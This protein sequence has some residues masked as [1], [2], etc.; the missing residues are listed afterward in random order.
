MA[1]GTS[2]SASVNVTG[3]RSTLNTTTTPLNSGQTY[4][5][6]FE[7]N[8]LM[9]VGVSCQTDQDGTLFFDF[10]PNGTDVNTFPPAGFSVSA[11]IHE[12]HTAVKL[13]RY[14][15]VR[16]QNTSGSNQTYLRLYTY[17]GPGRQGNS[18]IV[19][20]ISDD[21]D[22][23]VVRAVLTAKDS[24][25]TYRN[26]GS[27]VGGALL[28]GDFLTEV[29]LGH[30]SGYSVDVK[31]GRNSEV[32][33][34]S[35]PEDIWEG[36]GA[37]TGHP[38]GSPETV[39][40]FSNNANDTSAG[41]GARTIRISG[42]KST[43]STD[44]ESEDLTMNG[45]SAVTSVNTWYRINRMLVLTAGSGGANAGLITCRHTT[46][47]ANVFAAMVAGYNQTTILAYTVPSGKEVVMKRL[48]LAITRSNGSPGS[49]TVSMRVRPS[50]GVYNAKRVM[51][52]QTGAAV[53]FTQEGGDMW[54]AGTDVKFTVEDVSDNDTVIDGA[55]E[56]VLTTP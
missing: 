9:D 26:V 17:Y 39:E 28:T 14:F 19:Q 11:G 25:G 43:S 27:N 16:F 42:L 7:Q 34:G 5:G 24:D 40:V 33:T 3:I 18:P 6:T 1:T 37:Y 21:S 22:A 30:I 36:G 48:R 45:T 41:T 2:S 31:F 35:A 8:D 38:T 23:T 50:G 44:Y 46:T 51:E 15:R 4:T 10:S 29:A 32:D 52:L 47:T 13:P 49:A 12:F 56:Y 55:F 20:S 53:S 54:A